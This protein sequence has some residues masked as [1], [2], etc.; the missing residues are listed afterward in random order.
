M[1][2]LVLS[3]YSNYTVGERVKCDCWLTPASLVYV[4]TF[5][6][7]ATSHPSCICVCSQSDPN[8]PS[9]PSPPPMQTG[10][11]LVE[12]DHYRSSDIQRQMEEV[13][14]AW[15]QLTE[16]T[17]EKGRKLKD[18]NELQ[19]CSVCVWCVCI[20]VWGCVAVWRGV[21]ML[22]K[23]MRECM[24]HVIPQVSPLACLPCSNTRSHIFLPLRSSSCVQL[25]MRTSGSVRLRPFWARMTLDPACP[26]CS[27][28]WRGTR[29]THGHTHT[30]HQCSTLENFCVAR[31]RL[32]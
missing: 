21:H 2:N 30:L 26:V 23:G 28:S 10:N 4:W 15:E 18:A 32:D 9:L 16:A 29:Y 31:C 27:F 22:C 5:T 25:T 8:L 3:K 17:T 12:S 1:W 14:E 13:T 7:C 20:Y 6:P 11:D 24:K 19:V